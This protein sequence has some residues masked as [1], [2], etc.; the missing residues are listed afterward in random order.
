[1]AEISSINF[2]SN[3]HTSKAGIPREEPIEPRI[4]K[5]VKGNV[6]QRKK[7]AG[8]LFIDSFKVEDRQDIKSYLI[9]DVIAPSVKN[10][11][12]DSISNGVEMLVWGSTSKKRRKGVGSSAYSSI[13]SKSLSERRGVQKR[14]SDM[15]EMI[16]DDKGEAEEV[17]DSLCN[18]IEEY[19]NCTVADYYNAIGKTSTFTDN[20]WGW[21]TLA[22]SR[23][24]RVQGGYIIDLPRPISLKKE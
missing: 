1:M 2:P 8:R 7:S 11:I 23:T 10:L 15:D 18:L 12:V 5:I 16:F 19:G 22:D 17:L 14:D 13:F 4:E 3:S 24:K 21:T 9:E 6:T 20:K